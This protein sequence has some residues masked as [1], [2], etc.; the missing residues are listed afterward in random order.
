MKIFRGPYQNIENTETQQDKNVLRFLCFSL[1][2]T[3]VWMIILFIISFNLYSNFPRDESLT[4]EG[5]QKL[6]DFITFTINREMAVGSLKSIQSYSVSSETRGAVRSI[7]FY[8]LLQT[9]E[10]DSEGCIK[11][12]KS[13]KSTAA[14]SNY[15]LKEGLDFRLSSNGSKITILTGGLFSIY[16]Q[17]QW[18]LQKNETGEL[19]LVITRGLNNSQ[20]KIFSCTLGIKRTAGLDKKT[21]YTE[22]VQYL[23]SNQQIWISTTNYKKNILGDQNKTFLGLVRLN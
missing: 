16:V 13:I 5:E 12:W 7:E 20:S 1:G 15:L 8:N 4:K 19:N 14:P 2:L 21:C 6:K 11:Y 18:E 10:V 17:T 9:L 22:T 3:W 23:S